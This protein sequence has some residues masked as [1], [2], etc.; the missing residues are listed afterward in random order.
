MSA[1]VTDIKVE[2]LWIVRDHLMDSK[3]HVDRCE[4]EQDFTEALIVR[5]LMPDQVKE[6]RETLEEKKRTYWSFGLVLFIKAFQPKDPITEQWLAYAP[7]YHDVYV[8]LNGIRNRY[9]AHDGPSGQPH[10]MSIDRDL[11]RN[12]RDQA[13]RAGAREEELDR[14]MVNK[15]TRDVR[16]SIRYYPSLRDINML[17][18]LVRSGIDYIT[19]RIRKA[20]DG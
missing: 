14:Q 6:A 13:I 16:S 1:E 17:G 2:R 5:D 4:I 19:L 18:E 10:E 9:I 12:R 11:M 15:I 3:W 7:H 20:Q 8:Q